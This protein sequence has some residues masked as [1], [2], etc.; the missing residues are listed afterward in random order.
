MAVG[1]FASPQQTAPQLQAPTLR[2]GQNVNIVV[3]RN[4]V[5]SF[6]QGRSEIKCTASVLYTEIAAERC[7][8]RPTVS[9]IRN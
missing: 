3:T 6:M 4:H 5:V 9:S 7:Q 1:L 8:S 2:A